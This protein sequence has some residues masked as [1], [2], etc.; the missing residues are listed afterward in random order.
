MC[1]Y[2]MVNCPYII[3]SIVHAQLKYIRIQDYVIVE[4]KLLFHLAGIFESASRNIQS[5][6]VTS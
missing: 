5:V 6:Q 2:S 3:T 4:K 1:Y